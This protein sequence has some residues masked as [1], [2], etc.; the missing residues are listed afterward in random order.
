MSTGQFGYGGVPGCWVDPVRG[1]QMLSSYFHVSQVSHKTYIERMQPRPFEEWIEK[2]HQRHANLCGAYARPTDERSLVRGGVGYNQ[3]SFVYFAKAWVNVE[4]SSVLS[5]Y[6][7]EAQ[8]HVSDRQFIAKI[9]MAMG[10]RGVGGEHVGVKCEVWLHS[11]VLWGCKAGCEV[12]TA[13]GAGSSEHADELIQ[14]YRAPVVGFAAARPLW[15]RVGVPTKW[16]SNS[17]LQLGKRTRGML[18]RG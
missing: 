10:C 8:R 4:G 6:W 7:D 18:V 17:G 14:R 3:G 9:E 2:G 16:S 15:S 12:L 13:H 11:R 5:S 1:Y